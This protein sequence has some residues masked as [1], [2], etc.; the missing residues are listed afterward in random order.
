MWGKCIFISLVNRRDFLFV[1]REN[2]YSNLKPSKRM[3]K[4][5]YFFG[6]ILVC[7]I[8]KQKKLKIKI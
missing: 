8:M 1:L 5:V 2:Y 6:I 7:M 4:I 3:V